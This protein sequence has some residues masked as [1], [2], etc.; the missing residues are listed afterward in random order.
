VRHGL[1]ALMV[2]LAPACGFHLRSWDVGTSVQSAYVTASPRH[3]LEATLESALR[4]AGVSAAASAEQA[5]VVVELLDSR[6]DRRSITVSG[7]ARAAEYET[8][9]AVEYRIT[10]GQGAELVPAQ[11]LE[12]V[13]V[14]RV[15][16]DNIVGSSEEQALLEREMQNDLVQ[17]ILRSLNASVPEPGDAGQAR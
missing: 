5:E 2:T 10:D 9:L 17:Q 4:Q 13:R 14:F 16:R 6:S 15:D 11:W 1:A 8:T 7:Q 3:P 12:R